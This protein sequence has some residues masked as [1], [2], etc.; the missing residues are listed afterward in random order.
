M[1][2]SP[3]I[4]R[5]VRMCQGQSSPQRM[6][7]QSPQKMAVAEPDLPRSQSTGSIK[8]T[9][10][11]QPQQQLKQTPQPQTMQTSLS[12]SSFTF[13]APATKKRSL[14]NSSVLPAPPAKAP[15]FNPVDL[16]RRLDREHRSIRLYVDPCRASMGRLEEKV[17][18]RVAITH[19]FPGA[20]VS[21]STMP[22]YRVRQIR[23]FN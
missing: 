22:S 16:M 4:A 11:E 3:D 12:A 21:P 1:R 19:D 13:G 14:S 8:P 20:G 7:P 2:E 9:P 15:E 10:D 23:E 18:Q 17:G 5:T 6:P